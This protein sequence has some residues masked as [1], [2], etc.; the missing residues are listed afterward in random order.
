[1]VSEDGVVIDRGKCS[2]CDECS[3]V[4]PS[5]ALRV[6]GR[7]V[8]VAEVL[9]EVARDGVFYEHSGGG[10]TLS[11]GEPLMQ[12]DFALALLE[13]ARALGFH[14]AVETSGFASEEIIRDVLG[15]TD[16]ILYD[17]KQMDSA[18]HGAATGEGNTTILKTRA[19]R[20]LLASRW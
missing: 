20:Q 1:M 11:G 5:G 19:S 14:S 10:M 2:A 7:R 9:D 12:P 16:L 18:P 8:A 6:A 13:G 15:Q 17:I 3:R 4:C